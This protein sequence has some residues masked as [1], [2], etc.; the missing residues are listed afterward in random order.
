MALHGAAICPMELHRRS[1]VLHRTPWKTHG[2]PRDPVRDPML[3]HGAPYCTMVL[4][5]ARWGS[6]VL[7]GRPHGAVHVAPRGTTE[8]HGVS[9]RHRGVSHG[10]SWC[11]IGHDGH[12]ME[13]REVSHANSYETPRGT[14]GL[15]GAPRRS[16]RHHEGPRST[17]TSI[18]EHHGAPRGTMDSAKHAH[19]GAL[20]R[21]VQHE[22]PQ[23]PWS[24]L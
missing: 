15:H 2:G 21:L 11:T 20:W 19:R 17:M 9:C 13:H 4:R 8:H 16:M 18:I 6:M 24:V 14:N 1:I 23:G 3:P 7:H 5:G 10:A 22:A 12:A